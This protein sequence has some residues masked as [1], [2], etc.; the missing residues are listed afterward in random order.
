MDR[1][2]AVLDAV[3]AVMLGMPTL[4]CLLGVGL[5]FT[6]WSG[7]GQRRAL[8]HGVQLLRGKVPGVSEGG[9][10]SLSHFQYL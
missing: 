6:V 7:F 4:L 3:N 2:F 10:C 1:L 9:D 8:T 5:V